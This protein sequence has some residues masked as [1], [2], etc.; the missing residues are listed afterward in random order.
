MS[1]LKQQLIRLGDERPELRNHLRPILDS[2]TSRRASR[3]TGEGP[4]YIEDVYA[5]RYHHSR[6]VGYSGA[7]VYFE[8]KNQESGQMKREEIKVDGPYDGE[9]EHA[10]VAQERVGQGRS[11][12]WVVV[13][14]EAYDDQGNTHFAESHITLNQQ[15]GELSVT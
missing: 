9:V 3:H 7:K 13:E 4:W 12:Q 10:Y 11:E 8:L 6:V 1:D 14:M 2:L 15:T 5:E